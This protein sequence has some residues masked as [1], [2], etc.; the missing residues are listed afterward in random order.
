MGF[1]PSGVLAV[2]QLFMLVWLVLLAVVALIA[3][4]AFGYDS[5]RI[6]ALFLD[7]PIA[8]WAKE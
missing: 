3:R 7:L 1:T 5:A 4:Q 6:S 2:W 8:D